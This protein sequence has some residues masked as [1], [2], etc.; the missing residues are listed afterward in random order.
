MIHVTPLLPAYVNNNAYDA[1]MDQKHTHCKVAGY[2]TCLLPLL[3]F[4]RDQ[5][6]FISSSKLRNSTYSAVECLCF[7]GEMKID[8][9]V[10][11]KHSILILVKIIFTS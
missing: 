1:S 9:E 2:H 6:I 3:R 4:W 10:P 8:L 5:R 7:E 11:K